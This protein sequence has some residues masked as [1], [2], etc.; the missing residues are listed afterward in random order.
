[1]K[2]YDAKGEP[3]IVT[4]GDHAPACAKCREVDTQKSG[5]FSRTCAHGSPLLMEYL[6]QQQAPVV[7]EKAQAERKWAEDRGT[8]VTQRARG[9]PTKYVGG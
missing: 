8:F 3:V 6:A 9:V 1:M 2:F 7:R 4:W 5:T